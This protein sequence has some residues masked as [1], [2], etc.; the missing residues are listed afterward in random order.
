MLVQLKFNIHVTKILYYWLFLLDSFRFCET[1]FGTHP[2]FVA[3]KSAIFLDS[4]ADLVVHA[5]DGS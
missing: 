1:Y 3:N 2:R 4:W 5:L